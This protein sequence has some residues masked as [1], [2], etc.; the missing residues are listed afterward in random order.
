MSIFPYVATCGVISAHILNS[1]ND[2]VCV[3]CSFSS[4]S[5]HDAGCFVMLL[6]QHDQ[7]LSLPRVAM[8][9][10]KINGSSN[11]KGCI[12]VPGL[13]S[14]ELYTVNVYNHNKEGFLVASYEV[15]VTP[16]SWPSPKPNAT[17]ISQS[18]KLVGKPACIH[19]CISRYIPNN[20]WVLHG[21]YFR[22]YY[23]P[24]Y[25]RHHPAKW[26]VMAAMFAYWV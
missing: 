3:E 2:R 25:S 26:W 15:D 24:Q 17:K 11:V 10:K 18:T 5:S 8:T 21:H 13:T 16:E 4:F 19:A 20:L 1:T 9:L 23:I 12:A 7:Q 14:P 22:H 6:S